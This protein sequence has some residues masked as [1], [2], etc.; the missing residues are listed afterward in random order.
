[1]KVRIK[2]PGFLAYLLSQTLKISCYPAYKF[3]ISLQWGSN[4]ERVSKK[5]F[6]KDV[7]S[8]K[9]LTYAFLG[10]KLDLSGFLE[11]R[12]LG[13]NQ[14]SPI[15]ALIWDVMGSKHGHGGMRFL[16]FLSSSQFPDF[17]ASRGSCINAGAAIFCDPH[18]I[19]SFL[20]SERQGW[21]W[22]LPDP[23]F[24]IPGLQLQPC[25]VEL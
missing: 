15:K 13:A 7:P 23:R 18:L 4:Q 1:M 3:C 5:G 19:H 8:V 20:G 10:W 2:S 21:W 25:V 17:W 12:I 6:S 16:C 11:A 22:S 9:V 14:V 24:L